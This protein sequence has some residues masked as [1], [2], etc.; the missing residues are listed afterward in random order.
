VSKAK[1]TGDGS[2]GASRRGFLGDLWVDKFH[3]MSINIDGNQSGLCCHALLYLKVLRMPWKA[4]EKPVQEE[5]VFL[6]DIMFA[7][8]VLKL[9]L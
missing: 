9:G 2:I 7:A 6:W 1:N 3:K 8:C 5:K 4:I